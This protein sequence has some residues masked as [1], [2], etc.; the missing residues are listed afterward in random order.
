MNANEACS[1][2]HIRIACVIKHVHCFLLAT[3]LQILTLFVVPLS[4]SVISYIL[5]LGQM[6]LF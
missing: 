3:L 2:I 6:S 1:Y 4:S 5:M